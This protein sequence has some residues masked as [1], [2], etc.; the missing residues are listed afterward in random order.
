MAPTVARHWVRTMRISPEGRRRVAM[1][2]SLAMS[3]IAAPAGES[4]GQGLL[5]LRLG[6]LGEVAERGEAPPGAGGLGGAHGHQA[7]PASSPAK[8]GISS[9]GATWTI[10]FFHWRV[11]PGGEPP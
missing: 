2:A 9:P 1:P 5:G 8:I 7:P 11:G 10:A 3:W 4:L 6:D